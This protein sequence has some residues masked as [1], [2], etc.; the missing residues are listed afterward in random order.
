MST[1]SENITVNHINFDTVPD[2]EIEFDDLSPYTWYY[3]QIQLITMSMNG[4]VQHASNLS[5]AQYF[6]TIQTGKLAIAE[7]A[8]VYKLF[9]R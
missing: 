8:S 5:A 6:R 4:R 2:A 9:K 3:V 1:I 7:S